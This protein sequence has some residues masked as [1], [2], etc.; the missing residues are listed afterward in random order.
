VKKVLSLIVVFAMLIAMLTLATPVF[1]EIGTISIELV[2]SA[3]VGDLITATV[4]VENITPLLI[5]VPIHFNPDVVQL[6][7]RD[8]NRVRPG[9]RT[10]AD[11]ENGLIG[12]TPG[13]ALSN[14]VDENYE[15]IFWNGSIFLNPQFPEIDNENGFIRLMFS[16]TQARPI[17]NETLVTIQFIAVGEGDADIR[18][19]VQGDARYDFQAPAGAMYFD[20][21]GSMT[22]PQLNYTA[23]TVTSSET[24]PPP[25]PP[26]QEETPP[27]SDN[28]ITTITVRPPVTTSDVL[29][30]TVSYRMI[31]MNMSRAAG[32]TE[33]VMVIG[34][35]AESHI[36]TIIIRVPI[37]AAIMMLENAILWTEIQTSLGDIDFYHWDIFDNLTTNSQFVITTI[38][39]H[40]TTVTIDGIPLSAGQ[41]GG[42]VEPTPIP[43]DAIGH[44][45][46]NYIRFAIENGIMI[47]FP[48]GTFQP[49]GT[50]TRAEFSAAFTRF[51]G[52]SAGEMTFYDTENHWARGYVAAMADRGI[53]NGV[54]DNMFAPNSPITREQI[55]LILY[56]SLG[57]LVDTVMDRDYVPQNTATRAEVA[58][59]LTR[60]SQ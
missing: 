14:E 40:E 47:G 15:P 7:D 42:T 58:A 37:S 33:N 50:I 31:E 5:A 48:D 4:R 49:N 11:F 36:N 22:V 29:E 21:E 27:G 55:G 10:A 44:W 23:L 8:G 30:Y 16:N 6:V 9:V 34:V 13:E 26:E 60:L 39:N 24:T 28:E 43:T 59:I 52:F 41:N 45:G 32:M 57:D 2:T 56:R 20:D 25:P 38:S 17:V 19:A 46:E 3:Q 53:V 12:L 51:L 1:A 18:F 54:G 35:E